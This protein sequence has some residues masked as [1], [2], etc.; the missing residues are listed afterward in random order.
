MGLTE[1]LVGYQL[2]IVET[3]AD[4]GDVAV[5]DDRPFVVLQWF[6]HRLDHHE[7]TLAEID[8]HLTTE[9]LHR[10]S[11]FAEI[12]IPRYALHNIAL[13]DV[14]P[15]FVFHASKLTDSISFYLFTLRA[16]LHKDTNVVFMMAKVAI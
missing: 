15:V 3:I 5:V 4:D 9:R 16:S 14:L 11:V 2:W 13:I 7:C 1:R 10:M 12:F 6:G 8:V